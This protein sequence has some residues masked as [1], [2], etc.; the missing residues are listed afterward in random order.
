MT[1]FGQ[2]VSTFP[3]TD[4]TGRTISGPRVVVECLLR[5]YTTPNGKLFYDRRFG[6]DLRY[7]L[8]GDF[9]DRELRMAEVSAV[10]EALKDE[11]VE[12]AFATFDL[13]TK[14]SKLTVR[15]GG[16]LVDGQ[17]FDAVL[18][19]GQVTAEILAVNS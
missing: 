17:T 16:V 4:M 10:N 2:D 11:R 6:F 12:S 18:A 9:E 3:V 1:D 13:D 5:R 7:L 14:A 19:I 15:I 8:N